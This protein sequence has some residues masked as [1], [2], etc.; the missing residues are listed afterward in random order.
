MGITLWDS[1]KA[2]LNIQRKYRHVLIVNDPSEKQVSRR[3][4]SGGA[5]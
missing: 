5:R 4:H 2:N 3:Y 1:F